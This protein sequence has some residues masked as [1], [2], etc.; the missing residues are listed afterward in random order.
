MQYKRGNIHEGIRSIS[1]A[2]LYNQKFKVRCKMARKLR[3]SKEKEI[4]EEKNEEDEI[5][6]AISTEELIPE[7]MWDVML[8]ERKMTPS[9]SCDNQNSPVYTYYPKVMLN[10]EEA[11]RDDNVFE[12]TEPLS[13]SVGV[14]DNRTKNVGFFPIK[15]VE[16]LV[17]RPDGTTLNRL[18]DEDGKVRFVPMMIG[19]WNFLV[20]EVGIAPSFTAVRIA[21]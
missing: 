1:L 6:E 4:V 17:I 20:K 13:I 7:Q 21:K 9:W 12:L 8:D 14:D 16:V 10:E 5:I 11:W 19:K 18:T 2:F 3:R 15:G